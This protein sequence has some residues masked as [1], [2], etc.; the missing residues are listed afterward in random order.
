MLASAVEAMDIVHKC[1]FEGLEVEVVDITLLLYETQWVDSD[2]RPTPL[3]LCEHVFSAL[4]ERQR[5]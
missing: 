4:D 5:M 3:G 2:C 1:S